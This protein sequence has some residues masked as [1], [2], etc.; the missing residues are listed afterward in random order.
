MIKCYWQIPYTKELASP[1]KK[2]KSGQKFQQKSL[3]TFS[4]PS[5]RDYA[6]LFF[7]FLKHLDKKI[8]RTFPWFIRIG[9]I[10]R[11][12]PHRIID[13]RNLFHALSVPLL[14]PLFMQLLAGDCLIF[15]FLFRRHHSSPFPCPD[16]FCN[17]IVPNFAYLVKKLRSECLY[18][19]QVFHAI[20]IISSMLLASRKN[21]S[22]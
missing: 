2:Q 19:L 3:L 4:Y 10:S 13:R 1:T 16:S 6:F 7:L 21:A 11:T 8:R 17:F 20:I 12:R 18:H 14:R 5:L 22:D 15:L 9:Q